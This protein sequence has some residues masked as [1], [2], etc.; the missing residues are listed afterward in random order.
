MVLLLVTIAIA[1]GETTGAAVEERAL[2]PSF[3]LLALLSALFAWGAFAGVHR[4]PY[5]LIFKGLVRPRLGA[6]QFT[7][8]VEPPTF[9]QLIGFLVSLTG[10]VLHILGVPYGLVIAAAV[11]FIAAFLNAVFGLCLGC[12]MYGLLVRAK[13]IRGTSSTA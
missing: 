11:A 9:A 13:L 7:E 1:L 5:G 6:P 4:H 3:I 2:Q 10:L 8:P 12:E